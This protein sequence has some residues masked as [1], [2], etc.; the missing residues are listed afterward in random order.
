VEWLG[1]HNG[2]KDHADLPRLRNHIATDLHSIVRF[3][4]E[5]SQDPPKN[6]IQAAATYKNIKLAKDNDNGY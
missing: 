1:K 4:A 6:G 5:L 2:H 3:I